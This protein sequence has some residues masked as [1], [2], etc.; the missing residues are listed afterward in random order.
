L[1]QLGRNLENIGTA[2]GIINDT[3]NLLQGKG[4]TTTADQ[5]QQLFEDVRGIGPFGLGSDIGKAI[6][7]AVIGSEIQK[8]ESVRIP[9][10]A[11]GGPV[12]GG[13]PYIVGEMGPELF[14]PGSSGTIIPNNRMGGGAK[15]SITVNAGMGANGRQLGEQIVSAIKKYERTSGPVFASA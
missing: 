2:L 6:R 13:S 10:R 7:E 12:S 5:L 3:I 9:R 8:L 15:I 1:G 11:V 14:V 4:G